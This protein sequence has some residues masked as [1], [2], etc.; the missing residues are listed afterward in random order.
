VLR[1]LCTRLPGGGRML[2]YTDVT[3]IVRHADEL[4]ILQ[5][6]LEHVNHGVLLLDADLNIQFANKML[7]KFWRV[8]EAQIAGKPWYPRFLRETIS[9][10]AYKLAPEQISHFVSTRVAFVQSGD[11]APVDLPLTNGATI[12]SNCVALP[13]GGRMVTYHDVSDLVR[14]AQALEGIA[15]TDPLTGLYNRRH[16][17][18][19]AE[20]A[21]NRLQRY[22]RPMS[23]MIIDVDH[24]KAVNDRFGHEAGDQALMQIAKLLASETRAADVLARFGGEEFVVLLPET[25]ADAASV[26]AN[27]L[28]GTVA[29][30]PI[31]LGNAT[32]HLSVSIGVA[33]ATLSMA[34]VT[35]LL[36]AADSALY[37]AK[38]DGR[39]RIVRFTPSDTPLDHAAE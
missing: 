9:G 4:E 34:S 24:F 14:Q 20:E 17:L 5:Q 6:A 13:G 25:D 12:R 39:N 3:N 29:Q 32:I 19:A 23:L 18:A 31:Q 10:A 21:W 37:Q 26:L 27:R 15:V 8:S 1:L 36:R 2:C 16:F 28:C 7:R 22:Q 11:P 33:E 35:A 38:A 30:A